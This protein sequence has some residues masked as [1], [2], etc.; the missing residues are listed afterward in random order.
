MKVLILGGTGRTG[1]HLI[2]AALAKRYNVSCLVRKIPA[3]A[4][5][6]RI[7]FVVGSPENSHDLDN[8]MKG[9]EAIVSALNISR[10]SDFPWAKLRTPPLF[11]SETMKKVIPL[12]TSHNIKR[13]VVCSAWGAAETK[14]DLPRWFQWLI[15]NSNIG[16]AY[17]DHERQEEILKQS[18]LDWTIVRPTGLVNSHK[19]QKVLES[20]DNIPQPA[21]MINRRTVAKYLIDAVEDTR[22][23]HQTPVISATR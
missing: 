15:D 14:K 3:V 22:L 5:N 1:K 13:I 19:I 21:F 7:N 16:Y 9:C 17:R 18:A 12:A 6:E 11:L 10:T 2:P 4:A 20:Y 23:I 8:A